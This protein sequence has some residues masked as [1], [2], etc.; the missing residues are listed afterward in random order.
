MIDEF[1]KML[2]KREREQGG[3]RKDSKMAAKSSMAKE[4]SDMLGGDITEGI[5]EGMKGKDVVKAGFTSSK[6]D[7]PEAAKKLEEVVAS[8]FSDE[9]SEDEEKEY[10]DEISSKISKRDESDES[11]QSDELEMQIAE[12]E[13]ELKNKKR[14]LESMRA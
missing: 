12:L 6:E 3:P 8:K 7:A 10:D 9:D 11:E 13:D 14:K 5:K 2:K 4:L 1:M